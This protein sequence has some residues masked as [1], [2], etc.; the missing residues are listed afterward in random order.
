MLLYPV[1]GVRKPSEPL[2]L[3]RGEAVH[4]GVEVHKV[5]YSA[6]PFSDGRGLITAGVQPTWTG[7][8]HTSLTLGP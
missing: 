2:H 7:G 1:I 6:A 5:S 8:R 4:E 3:E